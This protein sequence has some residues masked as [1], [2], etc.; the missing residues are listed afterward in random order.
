[1][2]SNTPKLRFPEFRGEWR[3]KK[4]G[5]IAR[6][7]KGAGISKQDIVINGRTKAIRYGELYTTYGEVINNVG[8]GTNIDSKHL[9]FSQKND[10]IIPAS[11]ETHIDIATASCV[12]DDGIALSGDLNIIRSENNGVFL[13]YYLNNAKKY[14]IARLAQGVSVVHLYPINLKSLKL[15]L[16]KESE[17]E[18]LA[19]FLT[20]IDEQTA[21]I[22]KKAKLLLQY[23]KGVMQKIFTQK[24]RFKDE[25]GGDYHDWQTKKL[26]EV[27]KER[28]QR[29]SAMKDMLS[30]TINQGVVPFSSIDRKDNSSENKQNYK[31]VEVGD[32]AYNSMRMWQGASG[33]SRYAGIVSPA[34]TVIKPDTGNVSQFWGYYFKFPNVILTFQRY[35]QGLTSDTWNLKFNQLSRITLQVP[36]Q[37]EQQKIADFLTTLDDKINLEKTKLDQAKLFKKSLLQRMFV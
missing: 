18:K 15:L 26:G 24:L 8:S 10:V 35:S 29:G 28:T 20:V 27:F 22:E 13:S 7:S 36:A 3:A 32:I 16:P 17:Q 11:G 30:V 21:L 5:D 1:M 2:Q 19:R 12:L 37:E 31:R 23:K 34:Y 33:V 4:L 9:V 25:N 6:F 14:D